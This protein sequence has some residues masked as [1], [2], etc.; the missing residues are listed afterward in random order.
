MKTSSKHYN[1]SHYN[2]QDAAIADDLKQRDIERR[3]AD[4]QQRKLNGEF[5]LVEQLHAMTDQI[6][7]LIAENK[8]DEAKAIREHARQLVQA[9]DER[10]AQTT[11][12]AEQLAAGA[13][14]AV[15]AFV[16]FA[17][18]EYNSLA[19]QIANTL[20]GL[21]VLA[22]NAGID[23]KTVVENGT[24]L[25]KV[26]RAEQAAAKPKAAK[27]GK[28]FAIGEAGATFEMTVVLPDGAVAHVVRGKPYGYAAAIRKE[29]GVWE[30]YAWVSSKETASKRIGDAKRAGIEVADKAVIET[31]ING[32]QP[33]VDQ[34]APVEVDVK[35]FMRP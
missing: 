7:I 31:T 22:R 32:Q 2:A 1:G 18:T 29:G 14:A 10:I 27:A 3:I 12:T 23:W 25:Y 13:D 17:N 24:I 9:E 33:E 28:P 35:A 11:T 20:A 5:G 4:A 30:V 16:K 8:L 21:H 19:D 6:K 26:A 15:V 34:P